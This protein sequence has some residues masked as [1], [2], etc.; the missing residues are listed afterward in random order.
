MIKK[1]LQESILKASEEENA[2]L[3]EEVKNVK[4]LNEGISLVQK[5]ENLLKGTNKKII[6]IIGKQ[7]E[8][9][10]RFKEKD[11]FFNSVGLSKLNI[12]FKMRLF[13]FLCKF[14]VLKNSTLTPSYFKSNMKIIKKV[15][16]A[17]KTYLVNKYLFHYLLYFFYICLDNF[18]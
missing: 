7:G 15:C 11:E 14:P 2:N 12:Y 5:Y 8:L 16:K 1:E 17:T 6:N 9:L 4:S 18:I 3:N 13:K 10:K